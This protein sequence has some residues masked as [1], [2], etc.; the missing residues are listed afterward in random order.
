MGEDA[1]ARRAPRLTS[2]SPGKCVNTVVR[3]R[4]SR[5]KGRRQATS[6]SAASRSASSIERWLSASAS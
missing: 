5:G 3:N 4:T 6:A 2:T 1:T